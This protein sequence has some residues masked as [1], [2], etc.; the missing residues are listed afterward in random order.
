MPLEIMSK[1]GFMSY[2]KT[3]HKCGANCPH[4]AAINTFLA[5]LYSRIKMTESEIERQILENVG[6]MLQIAMFKEG[7]LPDD[8][9]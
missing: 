7:V 4:H 3:N 5:D 6:L 2:E 1:A 8:N 9:H